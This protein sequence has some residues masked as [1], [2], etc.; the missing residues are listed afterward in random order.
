VTTIV[1]RRPEGAGSSPALAADAVHVWT[2]ALADT[3]PGEAGTEGLSADEVSRASRL[4]VAEHRHRFVIAHTALRSILAGYLREPPASLVF[5]QRPGGK[6]ELDPRRHGTT[7]RFNLSHSH[8]R[9]LV[10]VACHRDI[11]IDVERIRPVSDLPGIAARFFSAGERAALERVP[12]DRRLQAF[13]RCWTLKEAC[14][15]ASGEGI[16]GRFDHINVAIALDEPAS[17][18]CIV[19]ARDVSRVWEMFSLA[20]DP[21][22]VAAVAVT[23]TA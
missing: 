3:P 18:V 2:I 9:A 8:D 19:D 4:H 10:A 15:K 22:Y 17:P 5:R 16:S 1:L 12:A 20:P 13:F 7:L 23:A 11:G 14:V 21:G 6:P